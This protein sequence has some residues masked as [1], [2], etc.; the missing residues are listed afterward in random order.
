MSGSTSSPGVATGGV[1]A[2]IAQMLSAL[3]AG[4]ASFLGWL[5]SPSNTAQL[6]P[7]ATAWVRIEPQ[8][9]DASLAVPLAA[10]ALDPLWLLGRQR[11]MGEFLGVDGGTPVDV[12]YQLRSASLTDFRGAGSSGAEALDGTRPLECLVEREPVE[13][14][15]RGSAQMGLQFESFLRTEFGKTGADPSALITA[16]RTGQDYGI[17][18]DPADD[19]GDPAAISFRAVVA[20]RLTD[21]EKLFRA[22]EES[23][24]PPNLPPAAFA[25]DGSL[26]PP[27]RQALT[28]FLAYRSSIYQQPSGGSAWVAN[29]LRYEFAVASNAVD[30]ENYPDVLAMESSGY[31]GGRVDWYAFDVGVGTGPTVAPAPAPLRVEH[32]RYL[33]HPIVYP[34]MPRPRFW[35][36]EDAQTDW[37]SLTTEPVDIPKM[38]I[39][40]ASLLYG[41]DWLAVPVRL[42]CSSRGRVTLAVVTDCFG[43][44]TLIRPTSECGPAS[45]PAPPAWTAYTLGDAEGDPDDLVVPPAAGPIVSGSPVESVEIVKDN[46]ALVGWAVER[47]LP[48]SL[49]N[50]V[51]A[52]SRYFR[53]PSSPSTDSSGQGTTGTSP[54]TGTGASSSAGSAGAGSPPTIQYQFATT[55]PDFWVPLIYQDAGGSTIPYFQRGVIPGVTLRLGRLL[56]PEPVQSPPGPFVVEAHALPEIGVRIDRLFRWVRGLNGSTSLWM[57]RRV[58][59]GHGPG[60]SGLA[61]DQI[62]PTSGAVSG[63]AA[64]GSGGA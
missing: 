47:V 62:L 18:A 8:S 63:S 46:G 61:F 40:E 58:L 44:R 21:G 26:L 42:P 59:P 49:D 20:R 50:G 6:P 24:S 22:L 10:P 41:N 11:Q 12:V 9:R 51:D 25:A 34:G 19:A 4:I 33:P 5:S 36:F 27:V 52:H 53:A 38:L 56:Q 54:A 60:A 37:G 13:L 15:L 64:G 2:S 3:S 43:Q 7:G 14:G 28:D 30:S 35:E 16:F 55:V 32:R 39:A 45:T 48:G 1:T 23:N 31:P 57:A 29:R 17:S